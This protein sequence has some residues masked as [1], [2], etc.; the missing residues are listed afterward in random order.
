MNR[1]LLLLLICILL[2][3]WG[4]YSVEGQ[5]SS[6]GASP[7][8]KTVIESDYLELVTGIDQNVFLFEG[9]VRV[10]GTNLTA[11]C[12]RMEVIAS[13]EVEADPEA[14]FGEIG[15]IEKIIALGSVV[16]SQAGR[17]AEAGRA[18][19]FP[20]EGKVILTEN[21]RVTD[22]KGMVAT[23]PRMVLNQGERRVVIEGTEASDPNERP[24]V[25]LPSLPDLGFDQDQPINPR[26][27]P[28]NP[29]AENEPRLPQTE[30][31]SE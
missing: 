7:P 20:R 27:E 5:T 15:A 4:S 17:T 13:R 6:P 10:E 2:A 25:S 23:G 24:T 1:P 18:E 16:I 12:D 30:E 28:P 29:D 31:T 19:I 22:E 9:N 8:P 14:T 21:P 3:G 26:E 11:A